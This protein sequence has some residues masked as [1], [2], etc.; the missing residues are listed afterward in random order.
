MEPPAP[1]PSTSHSQRPQAKL[2]EAQKKVLERYVKVKDP[3]KGWRKL[4]LRPD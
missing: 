3:F 2:P 4:L 1:P